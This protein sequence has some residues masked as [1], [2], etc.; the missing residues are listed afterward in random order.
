MIL[1][2]SYNHPRLSWEFN[3][4]LSK[5]APRAQVPC[6][7]S[8]D[9][10]H[11]RLRV[12]KSVCR[13][14][15][16]ARLKTPGCWLGN[17]PTSLQESMQDPTH[18]RTQRLFILW[19]RSQKCWQQLCSTHDVWW[20]NPSCCSP[21]IMSISYSLHCLATLPVPSIIYCYP[22]CLG[23]TS[24]EGAEIPLG[25]LLLDENTGNCP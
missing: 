5:R 24:H 22:L 10:E 18:W 8:L 4:C 21:F 13:S 11:P 14:K 20:K 2:L 15:S 7:F 12:G 6:M 9:G 23:Y 25:I 3:P 17:Q 19:H 1:G 16:S